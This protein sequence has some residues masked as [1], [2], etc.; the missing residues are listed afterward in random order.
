MILIFFIIG[1]LFGG[2]CLFLGA[3]QYSFPMA[4]LGMF[5]FLV[6]GMILFSSG[7]Q[8]DNGIQENPIGSGTFTTIYLTHTTVTDPIVNILANTFFYIPIAGVLLSTFFALRG[9]D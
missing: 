1:V 3:T 9:M 2:I 6:I 7:L 4:Y 8:I 5:C